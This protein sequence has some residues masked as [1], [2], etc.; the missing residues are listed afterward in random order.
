MFFWISRS[1]H[2]SWH[3]GGPWIELR[4]TIIF[5]SKWKAPS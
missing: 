2:Q 4:T 5:V 3:C 1:D